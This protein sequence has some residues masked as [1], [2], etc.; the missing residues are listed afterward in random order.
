MFL[1]CRNEEIDRKG[2]RVLGPGEGNNYSF[3]LEPPFIFANV[4]AERA[5][6]TCFQDEAQGLNKTHSQ[7]LQTVRVG[8]W[9][10]RTDGG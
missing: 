8:Q 10:N 3:F 7:V 9:W 2:D 1:S 6:V 5:C 4:R